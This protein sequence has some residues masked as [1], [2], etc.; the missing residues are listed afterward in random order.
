MTKSSLEVTMDWVRYIKSKRGRGK[1]VLTEYKDGKP[2][3]PRTL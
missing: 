1:I 3:K 2:L